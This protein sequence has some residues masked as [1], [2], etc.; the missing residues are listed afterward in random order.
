[1]LKICVHQ[2]LTKCKT[3]PQPPGLA[4]FL[5]G[6]RTLYLLSNHTIKI[7]K[8]WNE[9]MNNYNL[10]DDSQSI[11]NNDISFRENRYDQ[12]KLYKLLFI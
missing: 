9:V 8:E 3:N 12:Y 11:I 10:I 2:Y 7:I 6:I 1:M 4:V 5:R